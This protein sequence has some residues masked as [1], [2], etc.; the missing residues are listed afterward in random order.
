MLDDTDL[1]QALRRHWEYSGKD[2]DIS[3]EIYH[4]DAVLEFPQSGERF[5]RRRELPRMATT[6]SREAQVPHPTDH[7]SC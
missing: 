5:E 3:H 7:S 6:V 1:L 2:E 4:D